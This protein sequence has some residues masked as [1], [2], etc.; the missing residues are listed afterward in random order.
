MGAKAKFGLMNLRHRISVSHSMRRGILFWGIAFCLT[1]CFSAAY[2]QSGAGSIQGTVSDSTGAVIAGASIHIINKATGVAEDTKANKVGFY[3]VPDL[4]VGT[5]VVTITAPGMK[6][7]QRTIDLQASQTGVISPTMVAGAETQTIDVTANATQLTDTEDGTISSTLDAAR[8]QE[9]PQN[10]RELLT[11]AYDTTPGFDSP[12]NSNQPGQT[13]GNGDEGQRAGGLMEGALTYVADGVT[14]TNR[15]F[16]GEQNSGQAT[17]PD[18]DSIQQVSIKLSNA[19]AQFATPGTAVITTKSGTNSVHGTLFET[20]VNNAWSGAKVRQDPSIFQQPQYIRNEFGASAGGPIFLPHIYNGKDKSFWFFAYERYSLAQLSY[21]PTKILPQAMRTGDFSGLTDDIGDPLTIYDSLTTMNNPT[22]VVP[23]LGKS[24]GTTI[25]ADTACRNA[26]PTVGGL[27]NQIP[28]S[29]ISPTAKIIFDITPLPTYP[30]V[31]PFLTQGFND[32][33]PDKTYAVIPT[34]TFRLDHNFNENNKA[35]LRYTS[36]SQ[37]E[38]ALRT[39]NQ[40]GTIAADGFPAAATGYQTLPVSNFGAALGYTHIFSP[41]FFSETIVSNQWFRDYVGGGGNPNLDYDQMLGL[42]NNFGEPGFPELGGLLTTYGGT[43]FNYQANQ[44]ITQ[45]D[46]NLTKTF[47]KHQM[48][49]GG[50]YHHERLYY[51]N[52]RSPDE[53]VF[54]PYTT[55]LYDTSSGNVGGSYP[56]AGR[57]DA[58]FFLGSS[59]TYYVWLQPPPSWFR[60]QEVDAYYQDNWHIARSLTLNLGLRYEAHPARET[61]DGAND[62]LDITNHAIVLGNSIPNLIKLGYT[63]QPLIDRMQAIGVNFETAQQAGFP[64]ALYKNAMLDFSPRVGYAWQPFENR[65]GTIIRGAYGRYMYPEP[66]RNANP[67]PTALP[68]TYE[69]GQNYENATQAPGGESGYLLRNPQTIIAG[70][71]SSNVVVTD[72][73][74][75]T[76]IL[77]GF[78]NEKFY[79]PDFKTNMVTELNT[80]FEQPLKWNSVLRVSHVWTH[81]SNLAHEFNLNAPASTPVWQMQMNEDVPAGTTIGSSSYQTTSRGSWDNTVYGAINYSERTGYSNDNQ[82]QVNFQRLYHHGFGFQV[83]YT[84]SKAFRVG[85]NSTRDG[86]VYP[87]ENFLGSMQS[88]SVTMGVPAGSNG[89]IGPIVAPPAVP[90]GVA[91]WYEWHKLDVWEEY[92]RDTGTAPQHIG[93][94]YI[95][96]IPFGRGKK[97]F[98]QSKRWVDEIIGGY[99]VAGVGYVVSSIFSPTATNWGAVSKIKLYKHKVPITD[100]TTGTCFKEYLWF[101]GYIAPSQIAGNAACPSNCISGLPADFVPYQSPIDTTPGTTYYNTNTVTVTG[102]GLNGGKGGSENQTFTEPGPGNPFWK[103]ITQ[104]PWNW[105]TDVSLFKKFPIKGSM[106]FQFKA[107]IFNFFNH[108]GYNLPNAT[109]GIEA[110]EPGGASGASSY[111]AGRQVQFTGRLTF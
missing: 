45:I 33:G 15:N 50:R 19:S 22:C 21:T 70:Y 62:A 79:N 108:Q 77:P 18:P 16:G 3:Q 49:F 20:A 4:F 102:S 89:V 44:N 41:S 14:L 72:N 43:M 74:A 85:G 105:N 46:E 107:D 88:P 36:N 1:L 68:F 13:F 17:L 8:M 83:F 92:K 27:T 37:T 103:T 12:P 39:S 28:Y 82:L 60:D 65:W 97:F 80:T 25:A 32:S 75:T 84:Y 99:Q 111:N 6:T 106:Y 76:G 61:R 57:S 109:T 24:G 55:G 110:V 58:D 71:N 52:D 51:L 2:A 31:N 54:G 30:N 47:G 40:P 73:T 11:M 9:I 23:V 38:S 96:D 69:Y 94:N 7:Y 78:A 67:G 93:F 100:C 34:I 81:G 98:G 35:Y 48:F 26:F 10:T 53:E 91:P 66:T 42:P 90:S 59:A 87:W 86:V 101:N 29:R 64:S 95:V 63:T 104:G 5:Y 56:A